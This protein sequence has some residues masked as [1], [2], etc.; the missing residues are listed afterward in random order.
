MHD[1]RCAPVRLGTFAYA[2][3]S[4]NRIKKLEKL[5]L[6]LTGLACTKVFLTVYKSVGKVILI[7]GGLTIS[8]LNFK[9]VHK[10]NQ[11]KLILFK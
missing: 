11:T 9:S 2:H 4:L 6:Q 8:C 5:T 3:D 1:D 7:L 10:N